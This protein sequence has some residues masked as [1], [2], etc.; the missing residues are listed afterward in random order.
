MLLI[1]DRDK[2]QQLKAMIKFAFVSNFSSGTPLPIYIIQSYP[3]LYIVPR[4]L[5]FLYVH[6]SLTISSLR[7]IRKSSTLKKDIF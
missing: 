5:I 2:E 1:V 4:L 7:T 6:Q 3:L